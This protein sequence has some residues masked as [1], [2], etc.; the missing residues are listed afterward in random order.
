MYQYCG[1]S[2]GTEDLQRIRTLI[3][4][5]PQATRADLSRLVCE[6]FDWRKHD[7]KWKE[8][9]CRV[10]MLRMQRDGLIELPPPKR[11]APPPYQLI[12]SSEC[13][14]A[15]AINCL[16]NELAELHIELVKGRQSLRLWN[17]FIGRYHYLGYKMLPGAQLRYFI[18]DRARVLGAMGFG[19]AAWKVAS[20][21]SFIGWNTDTRQKRLHLIVN[22][23]RFL[24]L[25]WVT[26]RNLA[27]KSLAMVIRRL[28]NDWEERFNY[29]PVLME[30]FVE[31]SRYRGTCDQACG[32][33]M[34]G[35]TQGRGKLDRFHT[36]SQPVKS[37]WL[38][39]LTSDFRRQ[40]TEQQQP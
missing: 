17:Q 40:L 37:V 25:P 29:R 30:T 13:D 38:K 19:A 27:S 4:E 32:W 21:D 11:K 15:P 1:K 31:I 7:G 2:W 10:A 35:H 39:P 22:Q 16:V 20:R 8:M 14:P 26:C 9:S 28:P 3:A 36:K 23:A 5:S 33:H 24:I 34:V 12:I 18:K 6:I